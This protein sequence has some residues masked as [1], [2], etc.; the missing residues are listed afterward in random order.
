MSQ[1]RVPALFFHPDA[2]EG[3]G[4][5][6]VGRRSAGQ[7]FLKGW[8]RNS[9]ADVLRFVVETVK[10]AE[11][12]RATLRD[13]G[14]DRPVEIVLLSGK[15]D[16][17]AAGCVFFPTPGYSRAAWL[18]QRTDPS[19]ASLVGITHTVSTRRIIEALHNLLIEPVE[20]WDA[21]ICTSRA[22]RSVVARQFEVEAE[23]LRRRFAAAR[24]PMPQLPVI[25]LGIE[26][27]DFTPLPGARERLRAAH[28]VAEDAVVVMTMGRLSVV[29]KANP[30]PLLLAVEMVARAV[31][32]PVHLWMTG[33]AGREE[34]DQLHRE[35]AD[36]LCQRAKV[37]FH[38]GRD[39]D[40][41]R[42]IWAAADIFTLPADSIQE[43][44]GLVPVEAMA[45]GLPVVMPDWDGFRDTV[46]H[47][48]TG[49]LVPTR[50]APPGQGVE[51]AA[52]FADNRDGYL[53]YLSI[54]QSHVQIDVPGYASALDALVR[55]DA[56][57]RRMGE[58]ARSHASRNLDWSAV[59]PAYLDL[60]TDL[61]RR[62]ARG[63]AASPRLSDAVPNPLEIDPFDL[64]RHYPSTILDLDVP[65]TLRAR[66]SPETLALVDRL[67]GR[68][69][70]RRQV[71]SA[72]TIL[73]VC[74]ALADGP[75][76]S[77]EIVA[78]TGL[79]P[80]G[81]IHVVLQLAKVD[82]VRLPEVGAAAPK[83]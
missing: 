42:N 3:P 73:R 69:L 26:T 31:E 11:A 61:Y 14:E 60:A 35:A 55:N 8:L 38:D 48:E 15:P 10:D 53:Q 7:S 20:D 59:V 45:A 50:S 33:W 32:R 57:R 39:P 5:D 30:V 29:E 63:T 25:P 46:V 68:V 24:V 28:G 23:F 18:R 47:G 9:G 62:R 49:L 82:L 52:R 67:S 78:R 36:R 37:T 74:D 81:V 80:Q 21:I 41:R 64:Y 83:L 34:E 12:C 71:T 1:E 16:F 6:L 44:F 54:V 43:T 65:V 17:A 79:P 22:V 27:A 66:P 19:S 51:I 76:S 2:I 56:L 77:R 72:E 40:V 70:Y 13:L 58:A 75:L 4:R